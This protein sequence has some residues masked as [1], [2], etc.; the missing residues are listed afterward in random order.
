MD[1]DFEIEILDEEVESAPQGQRPSNYLTFGEIRPDDVQVYI[2]QDVYRALEEFAVSD[3]RKEL[4]SI[5]LGDYIQKDDALH[6]VISNYVEAKYTDAS[7]S[8]LTFTHETWDDIH[9]KHGI[10]TG[11]SSAGSI[12]TPITVFSCPIMI[13]SFRRISSTCR[14]RLPMSSTLSRICGD[15]SSGKTERSKS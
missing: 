5:L 3:T 4:G 10:R 11:K 2:R 13:C 6:V 9:S 1:N 8:T 14:F 12:H 7:A 15:F